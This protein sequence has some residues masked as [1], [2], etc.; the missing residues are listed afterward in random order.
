[1]AAGYIIANPVRSGLVGDPMDYPYWGADFLG[2][3]LNLE[4]IAP[5]CRD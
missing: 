4:S 5:I 1:M 3:E 2:H